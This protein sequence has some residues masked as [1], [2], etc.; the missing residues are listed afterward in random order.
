MRAGK[1]VHRQHHGNQS[2]VVAEIVDQLGQRGKGSVTSGITLVHHLPQSLHL[3]YGN[4]VFVGDGKIGRNAEHGEVFPHQTDAE[5]VNR[6]NVGAIQQHQLPPHQRGKCGVVGKGGQL[7]RNPF[8]QLARGG[9][10][11]GH[12]QQAVG[13][14]RRNRVGQTADDALRQYGGF[15]ASRCGGNK[16]C[17]AAVSDGSVLFGCP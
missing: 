9:I 1:T 5:R 13:V 8:A 2:E 15:S 7:L 10:G 12:D 17:S 16:Q 14:G 11:K 4:F 3:Q 6:G